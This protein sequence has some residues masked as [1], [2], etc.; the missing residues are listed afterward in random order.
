MTLRSRKGP[1]GISNSAFSCG[2]STPATPFQL[3]DGK[4]VIDGGNDEWYAARKPA[5]TSQETIYSSKHD[6]GLVVE[7]RG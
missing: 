2:P 3:V 7:W 1:C 4:L 6:V 5:G